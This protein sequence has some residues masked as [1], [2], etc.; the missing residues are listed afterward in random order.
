MYVCT[1][2]NRPSQRSLDSRMKAEEAHLRSFDSEWRAFAC[3]SDFSGYFFVLSLIWL[4]ETCER[5][6]L[7]DWWLLFKT[8]VC[9]VFTGAPA[10]REDLQGRR[11]QSR[12]QRDFREA[13][14]RAGCITFTVILA[15]IELLLP[16]LH[17]CRRIGLPV[18]GGPRGAVGPKVTRK[19]E[20]PYWMP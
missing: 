3:I 9:D 6:E 5:L 2:G 16:S 7:S 12:R 17:L 10:L 19:A 20:A 8:C 11:Q 18:A 1:F 4:F 15:S 13:A 14:E